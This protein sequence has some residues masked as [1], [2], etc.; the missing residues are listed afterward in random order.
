MSISAI[1]LDAESD[2]NSKCSVIPYETNTCKYV[3][4]YTVSTIDKMFYFLKEVNTCI[5]HS[6]N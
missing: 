4:L 5:Q 3:H 1:L 2:L 6:I